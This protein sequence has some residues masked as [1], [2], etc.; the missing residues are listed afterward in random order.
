MKKLHP[1]SIWLFF[2]QNLVGCF[3]ASFFLAIF[4]LSWTIGLFE[5]SSTKNGIVVTMLLICSIV[6]I[7]IVILSYVFAVLSYNNY[8]YELKED[9][10]YKESGVITKKYVTIPY[11]R[12]QNIDI[13]RGILARILGLSDLQ[14]QT[15][16]M[17]AVYTNKGAYGV[18]AEGRLPG[19]S[20]QDAKE[21]RDEL[22]KRAKGSKHSGL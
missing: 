1:N 22:I 16:G 7:L 3:F 4:S 21:I 8:K 13:Y 2:I 6:F 17:S 15:A 19:L 18:N 5:D 9:G 12:I 11:E 20:E 14:I 10:F